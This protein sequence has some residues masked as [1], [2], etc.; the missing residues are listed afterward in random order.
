MG[1]ASDITT[2]VKDFI[3]GLDPDSKETRVLHQLVMT[4][5]NRTFLLGEMKS[6]AL[7]L[8][9][10]RK[11]DFFI[12]IMRELY[13]TPSFIESTQYDFD[14]KV[15]SFDLGID[16]VKV[17]YYRTAIVSAMLGFLSVVTNTDIAVSLFK[18]SSLTTYI[19]IYPYFVDY[20]NNKPI[21]NLNI[22]GSI[23]AST[24]VNISMNN[25]PSRPLNEALAWLSDM[26]MDDVLVRD[27]VPYILKRIDSYRIQI[28]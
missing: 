26:N 12:E 11:E 28:H 7:E 21:G 4:D 22:Q 13:S 9:H 3:K 14:N 20:F 2:M 15:W 18:R 1:L 25:A 27:I 16:V 6:T 5:E 10:R 17:D 19:S 8:F 24:V 23:I